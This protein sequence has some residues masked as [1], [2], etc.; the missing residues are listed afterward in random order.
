MDGRAHKN[1]LGF[2]HLRY[3]IAAWPLP[4]AIFETVVA[5]LQY[6]RWSAPTCGAAAACVASKHT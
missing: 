1:R 3:T 2:T 6:L 4:D 5:Y